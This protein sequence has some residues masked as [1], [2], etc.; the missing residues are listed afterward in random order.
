MTW[1]VMII[2]LSIDLFD[3]YVAKTWE[4]IKTSL[5]RT[6]PKLKRL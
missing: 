1:E 5:K 4:A 6:K 2:S 3:V